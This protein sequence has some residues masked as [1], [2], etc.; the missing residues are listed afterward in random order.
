M[1]QDERESYRQ[2]LYGSYVSGFKQSNASID[3]KEQR[4][5]DRWADGRY[6]PALAHLKK[7]AQLLEL[8]CGH[9]RLLSYLK[10]KGFTNVSGIDLSKEQ[11]EIAQSRGLAATEAEIFSY[12]TLHP[13]SFDAIVAIDVVEHFTRYELL[14]LFDLIHA[15]LRP[16]GSILLQTVNSESLFPR[17]IMYGDL[18]HET[19]LTPGS[20]SQ[21]L[22]AT[23]FDRIH[24]Y[25]T[26]PLPGGA[27][28]MLRTILWKTITV[29]ANAIRKIEAGKSQTVWTENFLT[30]A[31]KR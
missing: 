25:D 27:K 11:I 18:T 20:M 9:G 15:S 12:L 1:L 28:G 8:G 22:S 21:L 5:F 24:Y 16:G 19:F 2:R 3:E 17:Q 30:S 13:S 6:F 7:D 4:S 31:F 29:L 10:T 23:G 26:A 14:Q